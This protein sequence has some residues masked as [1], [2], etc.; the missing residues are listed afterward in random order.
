MRT[1]S[2]QHAVSHDRYDR[3]T[4]VHS[5]PRSSRVKRSPRTSHT[6]CPC[7]SSNHAPPP[8]SKMGSGCNFLTKIPLGFHNPRT[9]TSSQPHP[10]KAHTSRPAFPSHFKFTSASATK[11]PPL[12]PASP[13]PFFLFC[14]FL[15]PSLRIPTFPA[16][17]KKHLASSPR[18]PHTS[19][20]SK[21]S[22][23]GEHLVLFP[24]GLPK[25]PR[26]SR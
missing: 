15:R 17:L 25:F 7:S 19:R 21:F 13:Q 20:R 2:A 22:Q 9:P 24:A 18:I 11:P 6:G 12:H 26:P 10:S 8:G 23:L 3:T 16:L 5:G 4:S 1:H 14:A